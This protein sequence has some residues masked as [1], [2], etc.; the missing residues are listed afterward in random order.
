MKPIWIVL[1]CLLGA[2]VLAALVWL[3]VW[4][5]EQRVL[6]KS[7]GRVPERADAQAAWE[8]HVLRK[9]GW[10][11]E[12]EQGRAA[13][14]RV[15]LAP[16][17]DRPFSAYSMGMRQRLTIAQAIMEAPELLILDEPTNA[18]DVDGI[19]TVAKIVCEERERGCTVLV[20]CHNEPAL[21]A[22]FE[23][24]WRM[25]DGHVAKEVDRS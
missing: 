19:E 8:Q 1:L 23:R 10:T 21:E 11:A 4:Y 18:L 24:S 22:L 6:A 3:L 13:L 9:Q 12:S 15:G 5:I 14:A 7:L 16:D 2:A 20:A 17:D 25:V